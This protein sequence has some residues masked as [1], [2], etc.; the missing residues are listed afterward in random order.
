MDKLDKRILAEF[1]VSECE[2]QLF[3]ELAH[4]DPSWIL[5]VRPV[6]TEAGR[7]SHYLEDMGKSYEQGVYK[8]ISKLPAVQPA[9]PA[10]GEVSKVRLDPAYLQDLHA[11]TIKVTGTVA[12][13]LE[14]EFPIPVTFVRVMFPQKVATRP[15]PEAADLRPDVM[16]V[17]RIVPKAG[18]E[19]HEFC[20]DGTIRIVPGIEL[21][22][23]LA[24]SLLDIKYTADDKVGKKQF[25]E[26][27][28]YAWSLSCYLKEKGLEGRFFVR[29]DANGI[30]P[31][32]PSPLSFPSLNALM[33]S[34]LLVKPDEGL[35]LIKYT[36]NTLTSLWSSAPCKVEGIPLRIQPTCGY[37]RFLGDCE[38]TLHIGGKD[39][40]ETWAVDLI[41]YTSPSMA[42]Q[43][44]DA[45]Y[46][47][48]GD[49]A[50]HIK[51]FPVSNT[52]N[53]I[54]P[55][56]SR[57]ELKA[58]ALF[59]NKEQYPSA[60][61]VHSYA[62]PRFTPI[63]ISFCIEYD[64]GNEIVFGAGLRL[65]ISMSPASP[66]SLA[67]D[68]WC[69]AW[70]HNPGAVV[71]LDAIKV[72]LEAALLKE[73]AR[74]DV[75]AYSQA[76][77]V[78]KD[79]KVIL[80]GDTKKDGTPAQHASMQYYFACLNQGTEP[81]QEAELASTVVSRLHALVT[82]CNIIETYTAAEGMKAGT[83]FVPNTGI[84]YW[85]EEQKIHL[86]E[87]L[88][89]NLAY[90]KDPK[91]W[92]KFSD[93]IS[94]FTPSESE[95]AHPYQ[96][97]KLYDIQA[98]VESVVGFPE[99]INFT[100]HAI[101]RKIDPKY[102]FADYYWLP[103]FNYMDFHP[104]HD[105]LSKK[106]T[107]ERDEKRKKLEK[108]LLTKARVIDSLRSEFQHAGRHISQF[109]KPL[110]AREYTGVRLD[111][112]YHP[113]ANVWYLYSKL[114]GAS[115]EWE[116]EYYRTIYP[117]YSI[118]KLVAAK[119]SNLNMIKV[120]DDMFMYVFNLVDMSTNMKLGEDDR[121]LLIPEEKRD[122]YIGTWA[123][124][125]TMTIQT[126]TWD[127]T[128]N[129]Y[130]V[131]TVPSKQDLFTLYR[132]E[133]EHTAGET[134]WYLFPTAMDAWSRKLHSVGKLPGFLER[135]HMG[136]SWLGFRLAAEWGITANPQVPTAAN[137]AFSAPEVYLFAPDVLKSIRNPRAPNS[138]ISEMSPA[139]D[140]SQTLAINEALANIIYAI[141]G[142]PGTGKTQTI[143]ALIDEFFLRQKKDNK[144]QARILV[145]AF[146]YA[147]IRVIIDKVLKST[148]ARGK[149]AGVASMQ[150][151]F[152]HSESQQPIADLPGCTHVHD[153]MRKPGSGSWKWDGQS[154]TV[155][156]GKPLDDLLEN[157]FILFANAHQLYY[158]NERVK[159]DFVFDLIVVD[160][161]SQVPTDNILASLQYI[162]PR[163]FALVP[164]SSKSPGLPPCMVL[165]EDVDPGDLTKVVIVGDYNQLPPVQPIEPPKKLE[166]ALGS[167]FSYYVQHHDIANM[168]LE[169]NYRS[170][171][172]IVGFTNQLGFYRALRPH[173]AIAGFTLKGNIDAVKE[174]WVK[175]VLDP[176]KVV[177]AIVHRRRFELSVSPL[178]CEVV[179]QI[180][181]GYY[182]M[183]APPDVDA[184][185]TFWEDNIGIVAPHNAQGRVII[186]SI[187]EA[188]VGAS[189][190]PPAQL[191]NLL[192]RTIVSVEKFQGS[193]RNLIIASIGISDRDLLQAEEEFI[194]DM[195]R[196]NVLTTRAKN[197][198]ILVCSEDFL[199]YIPQKRDIIGNV[200]Q[201]RRYAISYCN[202]ARELIVGDDKG[203]RE[204]V[205][206]RWHSDVPVF[207]RIPIDYKPLDD[208]F[209]LVI[210]AHE[211]LEA[212]V[213]ALPANVS[214]KPV[215]APPGYKG[216]QLAYKDIPSIRKYLPI[217]SAILKRFRA[218]N[219]AARAA[220]ACTPVDQA[221][222]IPQ[223]D[224]TD[225]E[226]EN[227]D[228]GNEGTKEGDSN[229]ATK[230]SYSDLF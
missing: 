131:S 12:I 153:L 9:V 13:L 107:A 196:F 55:E 102:K 167:L 2:R 185:K 111:E 189:R 86:Q 64:Q 18:V 180:V 135:K 125:W 23:R 60:G 204:I 46:K 146:S 8:A 222:N 42:Q 40:P 137:R 71:D 215:A 110:S 154:N 119:A 4:V 89:R 36:V 166:R 211:G 145:T 99:V 192:K 10:S 66:H 172:H 219:D 116:A 142:P 85:A 95:V 72:S 143:A 148:D 81:V 78:L 197:K 210:G 87:M 70:G 83:L 108:Q 158:L 140:A 170:H 224:E 39:H 201:V 217:G 92:R 162:K 207:E 98:F 112:S 69:E 165:D 198:V 136:T 96:H 150:M 1:I 35:R 134:T 57:L 151:V 14:H 171:A 161:A 7:K 155:T 149:P 175:D 52:P 65:F 223:V 51:E 208:G 179:K 181:I 28:Y 160:E 106:T 22:N 24:I 74:E 193:D 3:L 50:R 114:N 203:E 128:V 216:W 20:Y 168:Q 100:W 164:G 45:G 11:N 147:A 209:L 120:G 56:L 127:A 63:A 80:K 157:D 41:P 122:M 93:L 38:E 190:L 194:Y 73:V 141:Q 25:I 16:V 173:A 61:L 97:K 43:L 195:N 186:H 104:W 129:G 227:D 130:R 191:M 213:D 229:A 126:I 163:S 206:F 105:F 205:S 144:K 221:A 44:K 225:E 94:W 19:I 34:V 26:I 21:A 90:F 31:R 59:F 212:M 159:D 177:T 156:P 84:F 79:L 75:D 5:P 178:E 29:M 218:T 220:D 62:I 113:F 58:R 183:V 17:E 226:V 139:P 88:E 15:M 152:L 27:M 33:E 77:S 6:V 123:N 202:S 68:Q 48:I 214:I 76:T 230:D 67:F 82:V 103:H 53:P 188:V 117:E 133:V 124:E 132:D 32:L 174:P 176:G 169:T 200:A 49:V 101:A 91:E 37:C 109:A 121:V 47:N 182:A 187:Y 118:G 138:L 228:D 54:F 115:A 30:I 199:E 184:E